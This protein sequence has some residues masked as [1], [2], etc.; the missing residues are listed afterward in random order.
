MIDENTDE[1]VKCPYCKPTD[2]CSHWLAIIDSTYNCCD[3]GYAYDRY[4]EFEEKIEKN[5]LLALKAQN[6]K[7]SYQ[8][9]SVLQELWEHVLDN[10]EVDKDY[11]ALDRY[12]LTRVIK[13]LLVEAGGYQHPGPI[14][15]TG[16]MP[17]FSS[18]ISVFFAKEPKTVFENALRI[19]DERF[20]S[21]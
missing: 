20:Q 21:A 5:L 14:M 15:D 19:L 11:V 2:E 17:G 3:D 6:P 13:E 18:V 1:E 9:E 16:S 10:S 4:Y 12:I 7:S 8:K